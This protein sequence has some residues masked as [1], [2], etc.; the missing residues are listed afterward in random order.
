MKVVILAGGRG[1][2][3]AEE[4]TSRPKPMVEIGGKPLLWHIMSIYAAHGFNE[5]LVACGYR[6]EMIKEYFHNIFIHS[7]DYVVDLKDGSLKVINT[8]GTDWRIGV[9][10]TGLDTQTGGRIRRLRSWIGDDTFMVTYGDGLGDVDIGA[11][12]AFHQSHGRVATVTAVRPPARFGGLTLEGDA[13]AE[14]SEKPQV[15]EGWINGGFF[16]FESGIFDYLHGD[17]AVLEREPLEQLAVDGQLMA[18]RHEAFWQPMD[19][20]REKLLLESMWA[21]GAAPWKKW[22]TNSG[23]DE[24]SSSPGPPAYS[25]L[26]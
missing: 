22:Q 17:D 19:T 12:A 7:N 23:S 14:F 10:D 2:R 1:T 5:F 13:V 21:S 26:L 6:G 3:L 4:T 25:G 15:G 16:V 18:F 9:I 11:L 24:T 20:L 8:S